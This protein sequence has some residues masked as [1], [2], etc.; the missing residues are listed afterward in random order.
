MKLYNSRGPNP[1]LVR[2]FIAEKGL[3]IP[4]EEVDI[5]GAANR[6]ADYVKKNPGGQLPALELDDGTVIAE[7]TAICEYL[8]E[9]HPSPALIGSTPE[10]RAETR[11]WLRRL[12]LQICLPMANGF[13]FG[14][15][16]D[17]FKDRMR[18]LP[19]AADGLKACARDGLEWLDAQMAGKTWV[20]GERF[21]LADIFFFGLVSFF[22]TMGQPVDE[23]LSNVHGLL[24]RIGE[25][26]SAQA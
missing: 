23:K 21:T 8:E 1:H 18:V 14:E 10:E 17:F 24:K 7:T 26:P 4:L 11:M 15:A 3:D 25:R 16:H 5:M 13:R 12:E 2:M 22:A 19:E 6:Q 20:C 9:L